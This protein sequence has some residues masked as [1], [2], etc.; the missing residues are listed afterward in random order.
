[1][2][3]L[4]KKETQ[5]HRPQANWE[6][7]LFKKKDPQAPSP[8]KLGKS[9]PQKQRS[10]STVPKQTWSESRSSLKQQR[11]RKHRPQRN[12]EGVLLTNKRNRKHRPQTNLKQIFENQESQ[13]PSPQS[14]ESSLQEQRIA[15]AVPKQT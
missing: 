5:K 11:Y 6:G 1:V 12:W 8:N 15:S 2:N 4:P 3:L 14:L 7:V 10:A 13:A 9:T